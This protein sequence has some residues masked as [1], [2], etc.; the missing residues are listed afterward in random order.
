MTRRSVRTVSGG[1]DL[2]LHVGLAGADDLLHV[3][4]QVGHF[5][6]EKVERAHLLGPGGQVACEACKLN[7]MLTTT[8][9]F[10]PADIV[11]VRPR[12]VRLLLDVTAICA[13]ITYSCTCLSPSRS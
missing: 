5:D 10:R 4:S 9:R 6:R 8:C 2:R 7:V 1:H 13:T 11:D 3:Y 12:L